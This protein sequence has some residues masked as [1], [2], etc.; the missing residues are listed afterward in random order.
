ME[1]EDPG[2]QNG[3]RRRPVRRSRSL[4][5]IGMF[6]FILVYFAIDF[7]INMYKNL[8]IRS[9][10]STKECSRA[11]AHI[12]SF[13]S[14]SEHPCIDF[15]KFACGN[16]YKNYKNNN[17][18][19]LAANQ[20]EWNSWASSLIVDK[21]IDENQ[22]KMTEHLKLAR[23]F[24]GVCLNASATSENSEFLFLIGVDYITG[25]WPNNQTGIK[26]ASWWNI[27]IK[28]RELGMNYDFFLNVNITTDGYLQISPPDLG[29]V[30]LLDKIWTPKN[31]I[32]MQAIADYFGNNESSLYWEFEKTMNFANKFKELVESSHLDFQNSNFSITLTTISNL[33]KSRNY[34][35]NWLPF[36]TNL[37]GV[38]NL[39]EDELVYVKMK[40]FSNQNYL[41]KLSKLIE[42]TP[43]RYWLN[44]II[45]FHLFHEHKYLSEDV[46]NWVNQMRD[47]KEDSSRREFCLQETERYYQ[48]AV[49]RVIVNHLVSDEKIN[50]I[51]TMYYYIMNAF[52][53]YFNQ[54]ADNLW[55]DSIALIKKVPVRAGA[56]KHFFNDE[57]FDYAF[58]I[59]TPHFGNDALQIRH[60]LEINKMDHL[61]NFTQKPK[62]YLN[63]IRVMDARAFT[64]ISNGSLYLL[65]PSWQEPTFSVNRPEYIN[66]G[67]L[68]TLIARQLINIYNEQNEQTINGSLSKWQIAKHHRNSQDCANQ[69][70]I[71]YY[72]QL[73]QTSDLPEFD[74]EDVF[75][76]FVAANIAYVAYMD[77]IKTKPAEVKI[78]GIS[79][80]PY[81]VFWIMSSTYFCDNREM[82]ESELEWTL[83]RYAATTRINLLPSYRINGPKMNSPYFAKDFNCSLITNMNSLKKCTTVL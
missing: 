1:I 74:V 56:T 60:I 38:P 31:K 64:Y 7:G 52:K 12:Q 47:L 16:F 49:E 55:D 14:S 67:S 41:L 73:F 51:H 61:F 4:L 83:S 65:A 6:G 70:Y 34:D 57:L 59:P 21:E 27:M 48:K 68:G 23:K 42:T 20:K 29:Q 10:C 76:D 81:Q 22:W 26:F 11:A 79:Y 36:L 66:Y 17:L 39:S 58:G 82:E 69:S 35:P 45:V 3:S 15:S 30:K 43:M 71:N 5:Y 63:A 8:P 46:Q 77:Y 2:Q 40:P 24:Y 72:Q 75:S 62:E 18:N 25:G 13:V 19:V 9:P 78:E 54:T 37:T 80:D 33:N 53:T 28:S 50:H 32:Y 44:Y